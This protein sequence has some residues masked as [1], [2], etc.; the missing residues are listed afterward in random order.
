MPHFGQPGPH[1]RRGRRLRGPLGRHRHRRRHARDDIGLE[2]LAGR[3]PLLQRQ[4]FEVAA[5][6]RRACAPAPRPPRAR[7]GTARPGQPGSR[8]R[9]WRAAS[10]T[11]RTAARSRLSVRPPATD[12]T[13]ARQPASV[14]SASNTASLSSCRSLLYPVGSPLI[15]VSRPTRWPMARP[16][17]PAHQLQRIGILLLRHHAAA[18]AQR[19]GQLEEAVLVAA[20]DDQVLRQP[21]EMHH[22]HRAGIEEGRGEIA[23]GRGVHAVVD[24]AR[25]AEVARRGRRRR[26]RTRCRR[27]R[28]CPSGSASASSRAPPR[29]AKSRR[30]GAAC[31]RKKC[32]TSTGCAG[33]KC[34]NDGIS[35]SSADAA[36][37]GQRVDHGRDR[38]LQQRNAPA[39][40]QPQIERDLLV[41][42][43]PGVQAASRV[44]EPLDQLALD[45]AVDV[46]V[47]ARRRTPDR[48]GPRR[49]ATSAPAR[50]GA[51]RRHTARRRLAARA[52]TRCCR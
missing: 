16:D 5:P 35:A 2:M 15:V 30:S 49:A 44:A 45:E 39:Q 3:A 42:R 47:G 33:R 37:A 41:A 51:P 29:R 19:V 9:R 12:R 38:V 11:P 50:S 18:G 14:S 36:C 26:R 25:K 20:E 52:P 27:W 48:T 23:I 28:R 46:L 31:D 43:P 7:A 22:R 24:D 17:L 21:A 13:T 10:L 6:R 1:G 4:R 34:V 40:I 8:R 32:A